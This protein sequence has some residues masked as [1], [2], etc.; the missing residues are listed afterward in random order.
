MKKLF[1][2]LL[3]VFFILN[4]VISAFAFDVAENPNTTIE[5]FDDGSYIVTTI[6]N[7]PSNISTYASTTSTTKSKISTYYSK[8]N[9]KLWDVKVTGT[10]TYGNGSAKCNSSTVSATSYNKNWKVTNKSASKSNVSASASATGNLYQ[11]SIIVQ[12]IVKTV[13]LTCDKNGNFS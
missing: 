1:S 5:Y 13:T 12:S 11:D 6:S 7:E 2:A 3:S 9:S 10:F 4:T 8:S